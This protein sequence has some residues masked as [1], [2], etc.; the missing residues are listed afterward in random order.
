MNE[1]IK[2]MKE[3]RS[4]RKFMSDL[5]SKTDLEQMVEAGLYAANDMGKQATKIIVVTNKDLR[6][7]IS[8]MNRKIGGWDDGFDPFYG[9]PAMFIVLAEKDWRN[10]IYD[11]HLLWEIL[12]WQLIHLVLETSG[13]TVQEKSSKVM[14]E[15]KSSSLSVSKVNGKESDT[16]LSDTWMENFQSLHHEKTVVLSGLNKERSPCSGTK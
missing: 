10:K 9:A 1:I 13:F 5:P 12:C 7:K 16:A 14:K 6:D 8:E 4:I 3:R 15:K 2:A 11:A